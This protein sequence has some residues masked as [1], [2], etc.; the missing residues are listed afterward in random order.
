MSH[1]IEGNAKLDERLWYVKDGLL[2]GCFVK[3]DTLTLPKEVRAIRA[4]AF[5]LARARSIVIPHPVVMHPYAF[6]GSSFEEITLPEGTKRIE[7]KTFAGARHL[8]RVHNLEAVTY[9]GPEAFAECASLKEWHMEQL[10][11][12]IDESAFENAGLTSLRV[13]CKVIG[14][15]AFWKCASLEAVEVRDTLLIEDSAFAHCASLQ[16][17]QLKKPLL[18]LG[19]HAFHGC[20]ALR[21]VDLPSSLQECG[22]RCFAEVPDVHATV[23]KRLK[24]LVEDESVI[25]KWQ[26]DFPYVLDME[27]DVSCT[28]FENTATIHYV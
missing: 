23:S 4:N 26:K 13:R 1:Q 24:P 28:V 16:S 2:Y 6:C 22:F 14:R 10:M 9:V 5:G 25:E 27:E 3:E 19:D 18:R 15:K 12:M 21:Q 17:L 11:D 8:A 7:E 20:S